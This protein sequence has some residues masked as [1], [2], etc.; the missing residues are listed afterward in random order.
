M[1]RR[2]AQIIPVACLLVVILVP[3][4]TSKVDAAPPMQPPGSN[5]VPGE[6]TM[7]QMLSENV[8]VII[9]K[10]DSGEYHASISAEFL[11]EN[12]GETGESMQVRFP[13]E[14]I[15]GMGNGYGKR[16]TVRNFAVKRNDEWLATQTVQEPFQEGGVAIAWSTFPVQF[17]AR[18]KVYIRVFYDTDMG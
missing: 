18:E 8:L 13:M 3:E 17:P 15:N 7:V 1:K 2:L 6:Q 16:P 5:I 11:M 14:N 10:N 9:R 4:F 12:Q